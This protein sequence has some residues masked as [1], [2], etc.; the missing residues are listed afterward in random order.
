MDDS[1]VPFLPSIGSILAS[2]ESL[3]RPLA[4]IQFEQASIISFI[5]D[6][7]IFTPADSNE[8]AYFLDTY[9]GRIVRSP[10]IPAPP[11]GLEAE[12]RDVEEDPSYLVKVIPATS[13]TETLTAD[14]TAQGLLGNIGVSSQ[15]ALRMVSLIMR[16]RNRG[17]DVSLNAAAK[18]QQDFPPLALEEEPLV[19]GGTTYEDPINEA[20][21]YPE[22]S[23]TTT[24]LYRRQSRV[25]VRGLL[26]AEIAHPGGGD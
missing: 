11:P 24:Q 20:N 17:L 1:V 10:G 12:T 6:E 3:A 21:R 8:L 14:A 7:V 26:H 5:L 2:G 23:D 16:E 4:A 22:I 9:E 18:L 19:P 25:A 15:D 13:D